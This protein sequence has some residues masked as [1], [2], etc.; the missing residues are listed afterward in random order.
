LPTRASANPAKDFPKI[1]VGQVAQ[2]HRVIVVSF[3]FVFVFLYWA[4]GF[5]LIR[6]APYLHPGCFIVREGF[7]SGIIFD[8]V[9][10]FVVAS[11][12]KE[13]DLLSPQGC[14][15][16]VSPDKVELDAIGYAC[17]T[18]PGEPSYLLRTANTFKSLINYL[19][20]M[21]GSL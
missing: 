12:E 14:Y 10:A 5:L 6:P 20:G 13:T 17:F 21:F 8:P 1:S 9:I 2:N 15:Q 3:R 4:S 16:A 19:P 18:I 11:D 7:E